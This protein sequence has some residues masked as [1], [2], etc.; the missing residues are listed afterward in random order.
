MKKIVASILSC[1]LILS[2]TACGSSTTESSSEVL[3]QDTSSSATS[4]TTETI[5]IT[6][7]IGR[8][9]VI[10][11][12]IE[13]IAPTGPLAQVVLYTLCPDKMVGWASEF[14]DLQKEYIDSKYS[15]L[16][17]F[18][19]FYGD[20]LNLETVMLANPQVIFDI[21]EKKS[22][23]VEDLDEI[24]EKT[25]IPTVFI[26][27]EMDSMA[28]A[29]TNLGSLVG[30]EE[31]AEKIAT[32][33]TNTLA[34]TATKLE[35]VP[36]ESRKTVYYGEDQG[37]QVAVAGTVHS[38]VIDYAGGTN[39]AVIESSLRGGS[40]EVSMEQLLLWNPDV[41]LFGPDSIYSE[42]ADKPE[43]QEL[44]A[45]KNGTYY[46]IPNGPYNWMGRPPSVNRVIGIKWL[47]NLLYPE[48]F[49]YDMTK[50]TQEFYELFYHCSLTEEQV[51]DLLKNST[52]K[53]IE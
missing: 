42:V 16:P 37:L 1:F 50:E 35:Q 39:V 52:F 47:S 40:A 4:A 28:S 43:W 24:Q 49:D 46:E 22:S 5:T 32:Y 9:V 19:N 8:E 44:T 2:V 38:D 23:A 29:Y 21:G 36:E 45:I 3:S 27:M 20:T 34:D 15:D 10:P 17:V 7:D 18:G 31:Q 12:N 13:R 51:Q 48:V 41:I 30:E 6:D 26:H 53:S 11:A 33:I 14:T 25:G